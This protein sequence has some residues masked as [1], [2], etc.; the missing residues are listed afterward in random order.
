MGIYKG[1]QKLKSGGVIWKHKHWLL[2]NYLSDKKKK[3]K[4]NTDCCSLL[5]LPLEHKKASHVALGLTSKL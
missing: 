1:V 3:E 5:W 4:K 2:E